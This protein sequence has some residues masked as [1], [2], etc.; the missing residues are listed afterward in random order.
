MQKD[1]RGNL[2]I[3]NIRSGVFYPS[4]NKSKAL[5][6]RAGEQARLV[7]WFNKCG[8]NWT[9]RN[10]CSFPANFKAR[11]F[12]FIAVNNRFRKFGLP[13]LPRDP[14][15]IIFRMLASLEYVDE[16]LQM[17]ETKR[18]IRAT[19]NSWSR[20]TLL[21]ACLN[22]SEFLPWA[23]KQNIKAETVDDRK[24]IKKEV[25][26]QFLVDCEVGTLADD[27]DDEEEEE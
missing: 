7:E 15:S 4:F 22:E 3:S 1:A 14:R 6:F 26:L 5:S 23:A 13:F 17:Q 16:D 19:Y 24:K 18:L 27:D 11:V 10:H 20:Q 9:V 2:L 8:A 25:L 21:G 12:T